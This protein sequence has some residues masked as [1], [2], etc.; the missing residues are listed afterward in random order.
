MVRFYALLL[1]CI[2]GVALAYHPST[3][4]C[5]VV[6]PKTAGGAAGYFA[7]T[8]DEAG[9]IASYNSAVDLSLFKT[10]CAISKGVKYH[11][12][13]YWTNSSVLSSSGTT[14]CGAS[15][16]GGHY[17]PYLGCSSTSQYSSS[18]PLCGRAYRN[19]TFG[20][21]YNCSSASFGSKS[22]SVTG[23]EPACE[24]GDLSGKFGMSNTVPGGVANLYTLPGGAS[25]LLVDPLPPS[26]SDYLRAV[27]ATKYGPYYTASFASIVWH[28]NDPPS[29]TRLFCAKLTTDTA[30][31]LA[32]GAVYASSSSSP[33]TAASGKTYSASDFAGAVAGASIACLFVGLAAGVIISRWQ[34]S[35]EKL[36]VDDTTGNPLLSN[37]IP[38]M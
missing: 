26:V 2:M 18:P 20:Y 33:S 24:V 38:K 35:K 11:I 14:Y 5:A 7:L 29:N 30:P 27:P 4:Y 9:G 6:N 28:C 17:D 32:A 3:Q 23:Y 37:Q 1:T 22:G 19:S 15:F 8:I 25:A 12:H 34:A 36:R 16:T 10:T 21:V 31:C 13:S